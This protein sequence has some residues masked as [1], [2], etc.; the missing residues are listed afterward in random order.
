V[1]AFSDLD[2]YRDHLKPVYDDQDGDNDHNDFSGRV[3]V[4]DDGDHQQVWQC[5][6]PEYFMQLRVLPHTASSYFD[7]GIWRGGSD[8][9]RRQWRE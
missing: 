4:P 2:R 6:L 3:F 7:F 9:C 5:A 8:K 1:L